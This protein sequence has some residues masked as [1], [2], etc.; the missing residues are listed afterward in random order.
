MDINALLCDPAA[1]PVLA[2]TGKQCLHLLLEYYECHE[3]PKPVHGDQCSNDQSMCEMSRT[4]ET[5]RLRLIPPRDYQ[6]VG[7]I[8][9]FLEELDALKTQPAFRGVFERAE[10]FNAAAMSNLAAADQPT[11]EIPY[12]M[13]IGL[14]G[15]FPDVVWEPVPISTS[16]TAEISTSTI[17]NMLSMPGEDDIHIR[18]T[19][20]EG[21][22]LLS[23][24]MVAPNGNTFAVLAGAT[25]QF[26]GIIRFTQLPQIAYDPPMLDHRAGTVQIQQRWTFTADGHLRLFARYV[27]KNR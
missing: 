10:R 5:V 4:R 3:E 22:A 18:I 20:K 15:I 27:N 23:G 24:A 11:T 6:S 21:Q 9:K 16:N 13:E 25:N 19:A 1:A 17:L 14:K 12:T 2:R 26:T 7:P 8:G